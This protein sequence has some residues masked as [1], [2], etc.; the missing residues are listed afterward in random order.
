MLRGKAIAIPGAVNNLTIQLNRF[1][2]R[3]WVRRVV[4]KL[5]MVK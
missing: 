2:P 1:M 5:Q 3:S 4:K